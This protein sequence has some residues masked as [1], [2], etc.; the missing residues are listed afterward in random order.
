VPVEK[1]TMCAFVRDSARSL[2]ARRWLRRALFVLVP[3]VLVLVF[4]NTGLAS[5]ASASFLARYVE[6]VTFTLDSGP[7]RSP[8]PP[9]SG[10]LD[11]RLGYAKLPRIIDTLQARGFRVI[12]QAS[13]SSRYE[14]LARR[15]LYPPYEERTQAGLTLRG[16]HGSLIASSRF[17]ANVYQSFDE[18]PVV[19]RETLVFLENRE[20]LDERRPYRNP[21][22]D[23]DRFVAALANFAGARVLGGGGRFGASTLATQLE[24][25]RHSPE[26]IT[27]TPGDKARQM[28]SA[29][30]RSYLHGPLTVD[31][32][33]RILLDY[34]SAL[35]VGA[36][37]G[38]GEVIGLREG[39]RLWFGIDPDSADTWLRTRATSASP[40]AARAYRA[41][42]MLL[43]G[44]RRPSHYLQSTAG[45]AALMDLTASHLRLVEQAL[46]VPVSLARAAQ[47]ARVNFLEAPPPP[48]RMPFVERKAINA[49][50]TYL[51]GLV[52]ASNLYELDRYDLSAVTT[53]DSAGQRAATAL[54]RALANPDF[55][56][57]AG[58]GGERLLGAED[59]ARVAYSVLL[60][61][62]TP[63]GN[64]VRIQVDNLDRPFDLN[65]GARVELGSTAKLRTLVAYLEIVASL[66]ASLTDSVTADTAVARTANDP[67]TEWGRAWLRQRARSSLG[68]MLAAAMERQ[69][70]ASP[71]ESF[72]T[73][74]GVHVFSNFDRTHDG[75]TPTVTVAFRHSINLVFVRLMRDIV[76]YHI[77]RL[78]GYSPALLAD[79]DQPARRAVLERFADSEGRVAIDRFAR[80]HR[81]LTPDSSLIRLLGK[82]VTLHTYGRLLRAV[83]TTLSDSALRAIITRRFPRDTVRDADIAAI[84]RSMP[85]NLGLSDRGFLAGVD[86]LE[87][88]VVGRLR[89]NPGVSTA[90]LQEQGA[91]ARQDA[92]EWL[93]RRTPAVRRA[94]DR[95]I[96]I[97]LEREAFQRVL[98]AWR[99]VGYPYRDIVASYGTSIGSSGDRPGALA[100]L[101]GILLAGGIRQPDIR[102]EEL[103]FGKGTPFE[104]L[105]R[106]DSLPGQRVMATEVAAT[107]RAA[108]EDVVQNGTASVLRDAVPNLRIGG[109][110]GTGDNVARTFGPRGQ[111][112]TRTISRTATVVF[113]IGDRFFGVATAFVDG[114]EAGRY[115]FT[116]GLPVRVVRLLLPELKSLLNVP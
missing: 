97:I 9:G 54:L 36:V 20:L 81:G 15:G 98:T 22:V 68:D 66:H 86:P 100:E 80:L 28:A 70:T 71:S 82:R 63:L 76:R 26:G 106:R 56:A 23:W 51:A 8:A 95:S 3:V 30:L 17:P 89:E 12:Q 43:L 40:Q 87:L 35:P 14:I 42:M 59:P 34:L 4:I 61:E 24:K 53:I 83:D 1:N 110:T 57:L 77:A 31:V 19:I 101:A 105:L 107:A 69:Y 21:A 10:P 27:R 92:Y 60:Y 58:L 64:A 96:R 5:R 55:V 113:F 38:Y 7:S 65:L 103:H 49:A 67:I 75:E 74:G 91:R 116:S 78:P 94:Q 29:T 44:Q 11:I 48:P 114:P 39:L 73:G 109:K 37:P 47:S 85:A 33:R 13:V 16:R 102:L 104:V 108:M 32:R 93:F 62:R 50:R 99:R 18:I 90:A 46:V 115:T 45:R 112:S 25:L 41:V 6:G 52:G 72:F 79:P 84:A 2:L 88:W 111:V